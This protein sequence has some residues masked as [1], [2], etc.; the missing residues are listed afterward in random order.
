MNHLIDEV[1]RILG[2]PMPRRA[3]LGSLS[4]I[5]A[6]AAL[7]IV[8][9]REAAATQ[10]AA[11]G[12]STQSSSNVDT[13]ACTGGVYSGT[14]FVCPPNCPTRTLVSTT[15][16]VGKNGTGTDNCGNGANNCNVT[17]S[18]KCACGGVT[19]GSPSSF[20]CCANAGTCVSSANANG[21]TC[22]SG[23]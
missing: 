3:A 23:C 21:A 20:C 18:V 15:T 1:A 17:V 14:F 19:C 9:V 5:V 6:G 22:K 2:K 13:G 16:C 10:T 11:C 7:S 12:T 8:F 4:R